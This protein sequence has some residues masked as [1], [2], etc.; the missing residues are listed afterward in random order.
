MKNLTRRTFACTF[1]FYFSLLFSSCALLEGINGLGSESSSSSASAS[2]EAPERTRV[3][4][5][6]PTWSYGEYED[7]DFSALTHLNIAFCNQ[8]G[9]GK[10]DSGI[11]ERDMN[12]IV[13]KAHANGV[14]VM[15][16]LGG[17][18][19]GDPYRDLISSAEKITTLNENIEEF[20]LKYDLDGVDLDIELVSS[21]RIWQDYGA[22]V[23]ALRDVCDAHDWLLSTA[24]AQWVAGSV[25]AETFALFDFVNVM[26]YDNDSS[27]EKSHSSYAFSVE[28]LEYFHEQKEIP[29]EKLVLGVPFYG[30]G[31][32][33]NGSLD[34]NSYYSFEDL[35]AVD[36]GNFDLDVYEGIAYTGAETMRKKCVL[37]K[38]YGGIMIWEITLDAKGEYS[39]LSL[40]AEE[41]LD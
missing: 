20:C 18:G 23:R 10:M 34:W 33:A 8:N 2:E 5:Y 24:T 36:V 7:V 25:S 11:P 37:A 17:G 16:A 21:D 6:L 3:V 9:Q 19:Y 27:S 14:K 38:N 1:I 35:I 26:A 32:A 40:I 22:W 4:G 29:K 13:E 39:L 41:M 28:C 31:Y 12:A 30:R 15:A